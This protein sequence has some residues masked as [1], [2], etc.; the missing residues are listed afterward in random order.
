MRGVHRRCRKNSRFCQSLKDKNLTVGCVRCSV[1]ER[2][3]SEHDEGAQV[4]R[5][6]SKESVCQEFRLDSTPPVREKR[7]V[8]TRDYK[9]LQRAQAALPV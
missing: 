3:H 1:D 6:K 5:W 4:P 8:D 9:E 7:R 2:E